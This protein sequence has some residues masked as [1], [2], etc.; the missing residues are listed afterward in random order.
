MQQ[1]VM[2]QVYLGLLNTYVCCT[3]R[4]LQDLLLPEGMLDAAAA[5]AQLPQ[6]RR[7]L[8]RYLSLLLL[9]LLVVVVLCW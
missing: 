6:R 1:Q 5:A 3:R 4:H 8:L 9:L 2:Y 7:S